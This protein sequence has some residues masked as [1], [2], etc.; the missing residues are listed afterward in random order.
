[1]AIKE[2]VKEEPETL[3]VGTSKPENLPAV[4]SDF[5]FGEYEGAGFEN[6]TVDDF[7][8]PWVIVLDGKSPQCA[9]SKSGGIQGAKAGML[10]NKISSELYDGDEGVGFLPVYVET[11]FV[12]WYPKEEDGSGGG[13]VGVH[14]PDAPI[15][16]QLRK[17]HGKFGKLPHEDADG[18]PTDL[19]ETKTVYGYVVTDWDDPG[20]ARKAVV[21][22]KSTAIQGFKEFNSFWTEI[23]YKNPKGEYV[24]PPMWSHKYR[25]GTRYVSK[26]SYNWYVPTLKIEDTDT[27]KV[28]LPKSNPFF[29]LGAKLYE[30]VRT[31]EVTVDHS[32]GDEGGPAAEGDVPF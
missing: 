24:T 18:R 9:P 15:V 23:R 19:V 10:C 1:M 8:M 16:V 17:E 6:L 5:D 32:K 29:Q 13:F 12:E 27:I 2:K 20:T 3:L 31:G 26:N 7:T 14:R 28:F 25:L 11:T 22:F 4:T 30:S 21:A